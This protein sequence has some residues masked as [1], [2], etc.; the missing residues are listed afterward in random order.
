MRVASLKHDL[1]AWLYEQYK[2]DPERAFD[3]KEVMNEHGVHA[4]MSI[5]EY[6]KALKAAGLIRTFS[7]TGDQYLAT[8][9]I[10]GI[11]LI[12]NDIHEETV[13]LLTGLKDDPLHYYPVK[14]HLAFLPKHFSAANDLCSYLNSNGLAQV[15]V[16]DEDIFIRITARGLQYIGNPQDPSESGDNSVL[17]IA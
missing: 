15:K 5:A 13:Q 7:G 8:I 14:D 2:Q 16:D 1:L 17:K 4:L 6:G 9:S 11:S 12:S 10:K 3:V